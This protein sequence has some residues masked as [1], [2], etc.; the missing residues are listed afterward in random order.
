MSC[1][2][3]S[4]N[5][6]WKPEANPSRF[7]KTFNLMPELTVCRQST[8]NNGRMRVAISTSTSSLIY[9]S[10]SKSIQRVRGRTRETE[11]ERDR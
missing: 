5:N 6:A 4:P 10:M 9:V 8:E 11:R 1:T 2:I 3:N 7:S